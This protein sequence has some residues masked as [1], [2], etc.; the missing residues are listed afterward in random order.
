ME[1][2]EGKRA[3][4]ECLNLKWQVFLEEDGS[5]REQDGGCQVSGDEKDGGGEE[6]APVLDPLN[7]SKLQN[8]SGWS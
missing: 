3:A 2:S 5:G 6:K 4:S 7:G 8:L 1:S